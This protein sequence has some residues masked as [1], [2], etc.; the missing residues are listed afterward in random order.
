[1]TRDANLLDSEIFRR[2]SVST[3]AQNFF[4]SGIGMPNGSS[5]SPTLSIEAVTLFIEADTRSG[6]AECQRMNKA[7]RLTRPRPLSHQPIRTDS[8][9][10]SMYWK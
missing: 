6:E 3:G 7:T 5:T 1:M 9:M 2:I 8:R 4:G 10:T